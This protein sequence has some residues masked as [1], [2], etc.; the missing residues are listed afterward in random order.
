MSAAKK[1]D[2]SSFDYQSLELTNKTYEL[3]AEKMYDIAGVDL[4]FSPKNHSL[5]RNRLIKIL[6]R[7]D[8]ESYEQYWDLVKN[9]SVEV[10]SEFVSALTFDT[11]EVSI[12]TPS[13][14][15]LTFI[16]SGSGT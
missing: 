11:L 14:P 7:R 1:I 13:R 5:L 12:T 2:S 6:R 8:L 16:F 9:G 3:F 15:F 10:I 4:P